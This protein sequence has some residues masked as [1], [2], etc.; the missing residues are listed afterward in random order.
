MTNK[1][2]RSYDLLSRPDITK[3]GHS[4][5]GFHMP[6]D[7]TCPGA[8]EVCLSCC[9][10]LSGRFLLGNVKA[11]AERNERRTRDRHFVADMTSEMRR[12]M[13]P[14]VRVHVVGDFYDT[15]Y[16]R[17]W[18][19]VVERTPRTQF[20]AYTRSWRRQPMRAALTELAALSNFQ[21]WLS[22][23]RQTGRPPEIP[24]AREAFLVRLP[25]DENLVPDA[26]DLV[27]RHRLRKFGPS[28]K[29]NGV[30]VCPEEDEIPRQVD[31]SCSRCGICFNKPRTEQVNDSP[32][33]QLGLAA[34]LAVT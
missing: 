23:D 32:L 17:K 5:H 11:A 29:I 19:S 22:T 2:D 6:A 34:D 15:S 8:T 26:A 7:T 4:I 24:H 14:V 28:K 18:I 3:L 33:V 21:L 16:I 13:P 10:G 31:M 27:F 9:F 25:A 30:Q 12:K 20:F 1:P